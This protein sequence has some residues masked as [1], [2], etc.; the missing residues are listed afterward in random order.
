M[1]NV[2]SVLILLIVGVATCAATYA[3]PEHGDRVHAAAID[4]SAEPIVIEQLDHVYTMAADG[5]GVRQYTVA[6]R[7]HSEAAVR[8][9]GVLSLPFASRSEHIDLIYVRVRRPDGSVTETPVAEAIEMPSAVTTAAPFYSDLKE[10]QI[11]VRNLRVGD[12]LEWQAKFVRTKPDAPGQFWGE[13]SFASDTVILSQSL[14]LHVPKDIYVNVWSP[15]NKPIE[16]T[17]STELIYRWEFSQ[18]KPTVG[19]EAEAEKERKKK[20]L[21]TAEQEIE[22]KEGKLPSVAWTTFNNWEAV[23]AWYR[24]LEGDR[25]LPSDAELQAKV[26]E[27]TAGKTTQEEKVRAVYA[28][29]STQIRYIG[30]AF[31]IGRYQPHHAAE[32]LQNQ[33]GDCKDKHTLLAAMLTYLGL[34]PDAILI[35]AGVRFNEAVPSPQSFNHLITK[36]AVDGQTVWLD[37]T[38][39]VAPYRMLSYAIRDKNALIIPDSGMATIERT[40]ASLPFPAIYKMGAVGSLDDAGI[41][42]SRIIF[43]FRGDGELLLRAALHQTTAGQYDQFVQLFSHGIGYAGTTSHAEVSRPED[44]TDPYKISYDYKREKGGDWDHLR[45]VPQV[46]PVYLPRP[47]ESDPHVR[48]IALGPPRSEVSTSAMKLPDGWTAI[49]PEAVHVKC[50][51]ATYDETYRFEKGTVYAERKI[52]VLQEKVP[53]AD[54]KSYKKFADGADLGNDKFIRLRTSAPIYTR[55]PST[56][57]SPTAATIIKSVSNPRAGK[58]ITAARLSIQHH[59]FESAQS[60]LDE[61]RSLNPV[62]AYLWADY[63]YLEFQRGNLSAAISDYRKELDLYQG[64]Y[65]MYTVLAQAQNILGKEKDAQKTLRKWAAAQPDNPDPVTALVS[66]LLDEGH[67]NEAVTDAEAGIARLPEKG[68]SDQRLQL[69]TGKAQLAAD[70]KQKGEATLLALLHSTTDPGTMNDAA[71]ELGNAGLDLPLAESTAIEALAKLTEESKIWNLHQSPQN[72]LAQS[73][74]IFANWDTVGWILYREG[75]LAEAE[76]Y[77]QAAWV[78]RQDAEVGKHLAEIAEAKGNSEEALRLW[79]LALTTY[80]KY[81]RPGVRKTPSATQKELL[82]HIEA[83]RK[84][85]TK[86]PAGDAEETLRQLRTISLGDSSGLT[87]SAEYRLLLSNGEVLAIFMMSDIEVPGARERIKGAKLPALWPKGSEAKLVRNAMLNC[88]ADSCE[89]VLEP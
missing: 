21:W 57:M 10:L 55:I 73:R 13:E 5:T 52:E 16:S 44:T 60:Q 76:S 24:D 3:Q 6:S 15:T 77:I 40:P 36:V 42:N 75:K 19:P 35:G 61:A 89:L 43:T 9:L 29:V 72:T 84:A 17:S 82:E 85:G 30:V 39:E 47:G 22:D 66:L 12:R 20:Q 83:L 1:K 80:P 56:G 23:G 11:P 45:I 41:S 86:E 68:K 7:V 54:W 18:L 87:G 62:Q 25:V 51:W 48:S 2:T 32:V 79:E 38:T 27:L 14:E 8:Q 71:Y 53:V 59:E 46:M 50:Q 28:Y 67:A 58:L 74:R 34:H 81:Q 70:M 63:G 4:Y 49:L 78:N 69:L 65:G 33:Y 88:H 31:G 26:V 64:N 37:S